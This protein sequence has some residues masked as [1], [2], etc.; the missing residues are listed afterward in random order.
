MLH[1]CSSLG[2]SGGRFTT[3]GAKISRLPRNLGGLAKASGFCRKPVCRPSLRDAAAAGAGVP[4]KGR[5]FWRGTF[6]DA[7]GASRLQAHFGIA[8]RR[9]E[10]STQSLANQ[11]PGALRPHNSLG[12]ELQ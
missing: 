11:V 1:P 10:S 8:A 4:S 5:G 6:P 3:G 9:A 2:S 7:E 12:F